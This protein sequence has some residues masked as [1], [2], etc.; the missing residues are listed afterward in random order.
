MH[1][2]KRTFKHTNVSSLPFFEASDNGRVMGMTTLKS[3]NSKSV[4]KSGHV[5]IVSMITMMD[6][7]GR[8]DV[9]LSTDCDLST[10]ANDSRVP[11]SFF[12][13]QGNQVSRQHLDRRNQGDGE[14][15]FLQRQ[16]QT[17]TGAVVRVD[18]GGGGNTAVAGA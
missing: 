11:S 3:I 14:G 17:V 15:L 1:L 16:Q 4:G 13:L 10:Y 8:A 6:A 18:D 9:R 12:D 7:S 5:T 2:N